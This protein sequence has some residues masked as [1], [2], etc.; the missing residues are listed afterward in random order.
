MPNGMTRYIWCPNC[1]AGANI[2]QQDHRGETT[3]IRWGFLAHPSVRCDGC[4]SDLPAGELAVAITHHARRRDYAPWESYFLIP[5]EEECVEIGTRETSHGPEEAVLLAKILGDGR[6]HG[7]HPKARTALSVIRG[8]GGYRKEGLRAM[9][10]P[11]GR[12]ELVTATEM[13]PRVSRA[14]VW[15]SQCGLGHPPRILSARE[16]GDRHD[17]ML[18]ADGRVSRNVVAF[19][20]LLLIAA[21]VIFA[22][23]FDTR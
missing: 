11:E 8:N 19:A 3:A 4:R 1:A 14:E 18:E 2:T 6:S 13:A 7:S 20:T 9:N 12:P 5:L 10:N 15:P 17:E 23:A 22:F 16:R 21:A